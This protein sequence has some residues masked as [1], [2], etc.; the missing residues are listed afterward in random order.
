MICL[1]CDN[2]LA[3][4][5][6]DDLEERFKKIQSSEFI[7]IGLEYQA[8]ILAHIHNRKKQKE[9]ERLGD[10]LDRGQ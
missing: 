6:C 7:V 5:T 3:E 9:A 10:R 1:H 2:D 8:K 4:C